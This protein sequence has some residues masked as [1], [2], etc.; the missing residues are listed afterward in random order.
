M[1]GQPSARERLLDAAEELAFTRGVA[2]T[3]VDRILE[4]ANVS[5]ATL[6]AHFGN[7]EGLIAQALRRRLE[8]WDAAWQLEIDAAATDRDRLLA[9]FPALTSYRSG[10]S[11]ARWCAALGVAAE[12]VEP[13]RELAETLT[14]DT[15]L[16]TSRFRELAVPVVGADSADA[17]AGHL[18]LIFTGV[19]GMLLRGVSPEDAAAIGRATAGFVIDGFGPS[20][21]GA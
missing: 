21:P 9:V 14:Q 3:P 2:A 4:R 1:V 15:Q 5:P 11:A 7:K 16:L 19:L 10:A 8:N 17:V 20:R 12:T 13:G 18:L 6:Y